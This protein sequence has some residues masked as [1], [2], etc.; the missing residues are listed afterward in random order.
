MLFKHN[1]RDAEGR[2]TARLSRD[3]EGV[4]VSLLPTCQAALH[5]TYFAFQYDM[6]A[7]SL[8]QPAT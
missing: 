4:L 7:T 6:Q 8:L 5:S 2:N 3:R 1:N